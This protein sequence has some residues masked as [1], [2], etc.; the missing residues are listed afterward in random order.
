MVL[1]IL[2]ILLMMVANGIGVGGN[3]VFLQ[4]RRKSAYV[5]TALDGCW[6]GSIINGNNSQV[7][8]A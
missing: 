1:F 4:Q 2:T 5:S 7:A 8:T 6:W 3:L